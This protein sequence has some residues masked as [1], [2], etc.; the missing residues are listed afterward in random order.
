VKESPAVVSPAKSDDVSE[1]VE[2]M[3]EFYAESNHQ[4]DATWAKESFLQLLSEP[5]LGGAWIGR[6]DGAL[7]GYVVLTLG[8]SMEHG[9]LR[10]YIDD[11]FVKP[12]FR[13][14]GIAHALLSELMEEC[15]RRGCKST[16]V[17]VDGQNAAAL[18]LYGRFRLRPMQDGRIYLRA[19]LAE[20]H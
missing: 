15:R 17:E 18:G 7:A 19:Q 3:R 20:P 14:Q 16:H 5:G 11:L 10:G 8:Y 6:R 2:L 4:L 12:A 1:L 9:A 13:R